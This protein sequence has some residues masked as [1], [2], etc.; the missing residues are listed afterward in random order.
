MHFIVLTTLSHLLSV[1]DSASF[2]RPSANIDY[3]CTVFDA[4]L[5]KYTDNSQN[6]SA[7]SEWITLGSSKGTIQV[8]AVGLDKIRRKL[9]KLDRLRVVGL[10]ESNVATAGPSGVLRGTIPGRHSRSIL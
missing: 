9:S 10:D 5:D 1:P 3:G 4:L 6:S 7:G 2:I 8:E